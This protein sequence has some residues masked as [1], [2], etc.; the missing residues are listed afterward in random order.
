VG[1]RRTLLPAVG[2]QPQAAD[3]KRLDERF[4]QPLAPPGVFFSG[5]GMVQLDARSCAWMSRRP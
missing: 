1:K 2:E 3:R 5:G 4:L